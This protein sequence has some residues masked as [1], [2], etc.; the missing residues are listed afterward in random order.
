V[1]LAGLRTTV[2]VDKDRSNIEI[3]SKWIGE[4]FVMQADIVF[5]YV[6]A[7][8]LEILGFYAQEGDY[9]HF[10]IYSNNQLD[11]NSAKENISFLPNINED[12]SIQSYEV[13]IQEGYNY[14]DYCDQKE[15][16]EKFA[17]EVQSKMDFETDYEIKIPSTIKDEYNQ[18]LLESKSFY[19]TSSALK[20]ED[21]FISSMQSDLSI[22]PSESRPVTVFKTVNVPEFIN[23]DICRIDL[24]ESYKKSDDLYNYYSDNTWIPDAKTCDF[25]YSYK[26]D[27]LDSPWQDIYLEVDLKK[28]LGDNFKKGTYIVSA[29]NPRYTQSIYERGYGADR[30]ERTVINYISSLVVVSDISLV[31]KQDGQKIVAW[32]SKMSTGEAVEADVYG[33]DYDYYNDSTSEELLGTTD[34]E[35]LLEVDTSLQ[36]DMYIVRFDDDEIVASSSFRLGGYYYN[37]NKSIDS[38][39]FTD[40]PIY[41]PGD[42]VKGK[43]TLYYDDDVNFSPYANSSISMDVRDNRYED[44]VKDIRIKTNDIG[45]AEFEFELPTDIALGNANI[46]FC[47][48]SFLSS[49]E[50]WYYSVQVE[51]YKKP[52]FEVSIE[53]DKSN[54]IHKEEASIEIGA[55]Y[56]FGAPVSGA[57]SRYTL[58]RSSYTFSNY[59][60][61]YGFI[62]N[63]DGGLWTPRYYFWDYW[64]PYEREEYIGEKLLSLDEN[65]RAIITE[66]IDLPYSDANKTVDKLDR[67]KRI[68]FDSLRSSKTYNAELTAEDSNQNP[69]YASSSWTAHAT[70]LLVGLKPN[71]WSV[72]AG[73]DM[74][75]DFVMV[76]SKGELQA[77]KSADIY[78]I[79]QNQIVEEKDED[80]YCY[81]CNNYYIE[82]EIISEEIL[83]SND[84]GTG[85][86]IFKTDENKPGTYR[87]VA[88]IKDENGE[89]QRASFSIYVYAKDYVDATQ[90]E[91]QSID[92]IA[93]KSEYNVGD[94]AKLTIKSPLISS[95]SKYFIST[96]RGYLYTYLFGDLSNEPVFDLKITK[97]MIPNIHF[98][99][100]GQQFGDD[101]ALASGCLD[102][103]IIST[104]KEL[105][106]S[107]EMDK[108]DYLPGESVKINLEVNS[109]SDNHKSELAIIVVDK[110]NLALSSNKREKILEYLYSKRSLSVQTIASMLKI[111]TEIDLYEEDEEFKYDKE[112]S[113]GMDDDFA[114]AVMSPVMMNDA[115]PEGIMMEESESMQKSVVMD[116]GSDTGLATK[117]RSNFLDT[118]YFKAIIE[119]D[120]K[121]NAEL[122]FTL[123]DNLTTWQVVAIALNEE[124]EVGETEMDIVITN[125]SNL[126]AICSLQP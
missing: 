63:E 27:M 120:T 115:M 59:T 41:R 103:D 13:Y 75:I 71:K 14:Y 48:K 124:Y 31:I 66:L 38:Y 74:P 125:P 30:K 65:G 69:I 5:N 24:L 84:N 54:Y 73:E 25:F 86:Y 108:Q 68:E 15:Y 62:F 100:L 96:E 94:T 36:Y 10:C 34:K 37:I 58:K 111:V 7:P 46:N 39:I 3:D 118:A 81:W 122:E 78:I 109:P 26:Q 70:N 8:K 55:N 23:I 110:A 19:H 6:V 121:G 1:V 2:L 35:G 105:G 33:I 113:F 4:E 47:R 98:C 44:I 99:V 77:S 93:D 106:L 97:E 43:I 82:E 117:K 9:K 88:E 90:L 28:V 12:I 32:L 83:V 112:R 45:S 79:Y 72:K 101:L 11:I 61:E 60:K 16:H 91:E 56:Y 107:I 123:P 67:N 51:E 95:S 85:E 53:S 40:R 20:D 87:V 17:I 49:G 80:Y 64:T 104:E 21:I 18:N 119:T 42:T 116:S 57:E 22:A 76:N 52:E 126:L 102:L 89:L 114:G 50:C 29:S 92:I